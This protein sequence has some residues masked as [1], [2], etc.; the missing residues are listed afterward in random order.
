MIIRRR[1]RVWKLVVLVLLVGFSQS[2]VFMLPIAH[3]AQ[4]DITPPP[5]EFDN[6]LAVSISPSKVKES[7]DF[8]TQALMDPWDM[9]EFSDISR[10]LNEFECGPAPDEH[11][12]S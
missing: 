9:T 5:A 8:A 7:N 1:F 6:A 11:S 12:S 4:A 3:A 10:Y 2:G